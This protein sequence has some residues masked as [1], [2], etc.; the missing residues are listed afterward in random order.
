MMDGTLAAVQRLTAQVERGVDM[1]Q[2]IADSLEVL[3]YYAG[4]EHDGGDEEQGHTSLSD[5]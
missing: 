1:L 4:Q 5:Q 2:R 3:T